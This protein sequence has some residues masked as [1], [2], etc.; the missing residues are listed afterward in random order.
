MSW[1][2]APTGLLR[3]PV[4]ARWWKREEGGGEECVEVAARGFCMGG[5]TRQ[6]N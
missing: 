5:Y 3:L 4:P 2:L 6:M 1:L